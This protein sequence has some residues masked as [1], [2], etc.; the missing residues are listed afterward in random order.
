M[1]REY[2]E[3]A[4]PADDSYT[5]LQRFATDVQNAF[6]EVS[7]Q[8]AERE[9]L[10]NL[11]PSFSGNVDMQGH[12]ITEVGAAT[13]EE[14]AVRRG[15]L[16]NVLASLNPTRLITLG[17]DRIL[18][19][20]G[21]SVDTEALYPEE[22]SELTLGTSGLCWSNIYGD[23]GVTACSMRKYK[24][25]IRTQ[26]LGLAFLLAHQELSWT[27]I[28]KKGGEARGR[29]RGFIAEDVLAILDEF[30]YE[31]DF[32]GIVQETTH[33]GEK[34]YGIRYEQYIP[35]LVKALKEVYFEVVALR[36]RVDKTE[37]IR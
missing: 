23:A 28:K 6:L 15:G 37:D 27:W 7:R 25:N 17:S 26:T 3:I 22:D 31:E 9:G 4:P 1:P 24:T 30:E 33:A 2:F 18:Q 14:D 29:F 20:V 16:E 12:R 19:S 11:T 21:I 35:I 8:L 34:W 36:D 13:E 5:E 10:D 32:A